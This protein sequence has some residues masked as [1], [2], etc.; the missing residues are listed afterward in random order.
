MTE[1]KRETEAITN[2][3]QWMY[4]TNKSNGGKH[5]TPF[6]GDFF[7]LYISHAR[8]RAVL[9]CFEREKEREMKKEMASVG[10][11]LF[12]PAQCVEPVFFVH[13]SFFFKTI[14]IFLMRK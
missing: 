6:G 3:S 5:C 13:F 1:F 7:L 2:S 8:K 9:V 12:Q 11:S 14:S 10:L 4:D